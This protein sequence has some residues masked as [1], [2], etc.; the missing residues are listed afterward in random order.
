MIKEIN[1]EVEKAIR[2][3]VN[4]YPFSSK[5]DKKFR[6][7]HAIRVWNYLY[8]KWFKKDVV[9]AWF[10][11]DM[12]ESTAI[13]K[14]ELINEFSIEIYE[15]I[16]ANSKDSTVLNPLERIDNLIMRC[17]LKWE[18]ALIIKCADLV[19]NFKWYSAV[20]NNDELI[21]YWMNNIKALLK[22]KPDAF[23]NEVFDELMIWYN[24]F[25]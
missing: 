8:E 17:S 11:H 21:N 9:I 24:K 2:L 6:L 10:L 23:D 13:T 3:M 1:F 18:D 25:I 14:D 4:F 16:L 20:N 22:H 7:F 19:D 12:I 15:L 5:D